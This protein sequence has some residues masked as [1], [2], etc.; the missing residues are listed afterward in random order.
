MVKASVINHVTQ[1]VNFMGKTSDYNH[2]IGLK[3]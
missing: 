2:A 3:A 1:L